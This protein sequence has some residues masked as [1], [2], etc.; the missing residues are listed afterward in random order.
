MFSPEGLSHHRSLERSWYRQCRRSHVVCPFTPRY[1][2]AMT[3]GDDLGAREYARICNIA[4]SAWQARSGRLAMRLALI[5]GGAA[6]LGLGLQWFFTAW[7]FLLYNQV[8]AVQ[9]SIF[10]LIRCCMLAS[11]LALPMGL[12]LAVL[13]VRD[14]VRLLPEPAGAVGARLFPHWLRLVRRAVYLTVGQ[15]VLLPTLVLCLSSTLY[16]YFW[17]LHSN[18]GAGMAMMLATTA[19]FNLLLLVG[20]LACLLEWQVLL[21]SRQP[22]HGRLLWLQALPYGLSISSGLLGLAW[23]LVLWRVPVLLR[24][25]GL[26][27]SGQPRPILAF[28]ALLLL[29]LGLTLAPT[30]WRWVAADIT[31]RRWGIVALLGLIALA[32]PYRE[33]ISTLSTDGQPLLRFTA[34]S[35][36]GLLLG[37]APPPVLKSLLDAIETQPGNALLGTGVRVG[38]GMFMPW[39]ML[40]ALLAGYFGYCYVALRRVAETAPRESVAKAL[41]PP[42]R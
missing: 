32:L 9:I 42:A 17:G 22:L 1:N 19:L 24:Q 31:A 15:L 14:M 21:L 5:F 38:S 23:N 34:Y 8:R 37:N 26:G 7:D 40:L 28:V 41:P 36:T 12:L 20:G 10:V 27:A 18:T 30:L 35:A 13:R 25:S 16:Y 6:L 3:D 2:L 29:G 4:Q 33:T 39:F 11:G